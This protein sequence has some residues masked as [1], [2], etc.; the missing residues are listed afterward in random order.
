MDEKIKVLRKKEFDPTPLAF[1]TMDSVASCQMAI[2]AV[3]D[4]SPLQLLAKP[5]PAPAN[6][7][8]TNTYLPRSSRMLRAWSITLLIT[9]LT[10]FWSILLVPVAAALNLESIHRVFPRLAEA[11]EAHPNAASL[12]RTQLPTLVISLLNVAVPYLYDCMFSFLQA[13]DFR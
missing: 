1:V 2:Q 4:P 5:S 9:I 7:V 13:K 11:L 10:I 6:V 3:L 8:W 12:V